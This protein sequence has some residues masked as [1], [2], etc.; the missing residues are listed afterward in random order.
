MPPISSAVFAEPVAGQ[1]VYTKV[2]CYK[3]EAA[4]RAHSS[5]DLI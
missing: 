4:S 3:N 1:Y 5:S 2:C